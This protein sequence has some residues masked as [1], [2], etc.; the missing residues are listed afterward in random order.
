[1]RWT[2]RRARRA[3]LTRTAKSCGPDAPALASSSREAS[4][5]GAMVT[6]KPVTKESTKETVKP[7]R[8]E[9][10]MI[11]LNLWFLTP[12]LSSLHR[13]PRVQSAPGFPRSLLRVAPRPLFWGET[14]CK[15]RAHGVR[16]NA[17]AHPTVIAR[18]ALAT[19]RS[20]SSFVVLDCFAC[21]R[22]DGSHLPKSAS[23]HT[24]ST[25]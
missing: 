23:P 24:A 19:K 17:A 10:R 8:G 14:I 12:V 22:N 2:R 5:L 21:A 20:S 16:E 15:T 4:F 3:A 13:R 6:I 7:L 18:S 11:R 25:R 1:M 9:S